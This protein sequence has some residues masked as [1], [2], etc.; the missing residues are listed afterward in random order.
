MSL[1]TL[2]G[3]IHEKDEL[4]EKLNEEIKVKDKFIQLMFKEN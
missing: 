3:F 4:I 2:N 1:T